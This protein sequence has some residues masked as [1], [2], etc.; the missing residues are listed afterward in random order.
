[1]KFSYPII[2][3]FYQTIFIFVV[4]IYY[5]KNYTIYIILSLQIFYLLFIIRFW[6]YN[7]P[8]KINRILHNCTICYHQFVSIFMAIIILRW[9]TI[10]SANQQ[11]KSNMEL[12]IYSFIVAILLILAI[13][14]AII[15]L[16]I[17]NK[18]VDC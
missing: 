2:Y 5:H 7:T 9:K 4:S 1:M 15:R 3:L 13:V 8:R 11:L 18:D 16:S 12:Q 10:L 17:F 14:L 6:P